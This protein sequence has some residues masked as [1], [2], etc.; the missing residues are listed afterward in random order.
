MTIPYL[1]VL[2]ALS[3][4]FYISIINIICIFDN[5][6]NLIGSDKSRCSIFFF[7]ILKCNIIS[8][9]VSVKRHQ[10]E[11][12]Y[13]TLNTSIIPMIN[14][15]I[16]YAIFRLTMKIKLYSFDIHSII[17]AN[18]DITTIKESWCKFFKQFLK[19]IFINV[20]LDFTFKIFQFF[21]QTFHN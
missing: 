16:F 6:P 1:L 2:F 21:F 11:I 12:G 9:C 13:T 10:W 4:L 15:G 20:F 8:R 18:L 19:F 14:D 7:L 3:K 17:I 5:I